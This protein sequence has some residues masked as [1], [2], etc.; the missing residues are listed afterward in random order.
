MSEVGR[1]K[2]KPIVIGG[3]PL[4]GEWF[5]VNLKMIIQKSYLF[6]K[7]REDFPQ[8]WMRDDVLKAID[9]A[10]NNPKKY[11][12][13]IQVLFP[14]KTWSKRTVKE[15]IE[16]AQNYSEETFV[17]DDV[18]DRLVQAQAICNRGENAWD[19]L[20]NK[21]DFMQYSR[22]VLKNSANNKVYY[23]GGSR[24][25]FISTS[26]VEFMRSTTVDSDEPC[27]LA[28][29]GVWRILSYV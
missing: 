21:R 28:I 18:V 6:E 20:C 23:Y 17:V 15:V 25:S 2:K 16:W 9:I 14:E 24:T 13:R 7:K 22:L 19:L 3:F 10:K 5:E 27:E 1:R 8:D 26:Y 29:P 4:Q 12:T 11:G